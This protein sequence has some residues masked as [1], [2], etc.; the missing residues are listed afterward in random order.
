MGTIVSRK[1]ADGSKG[2][3]GPIVIKKLGQ[4]VHRE[5]QTIDSHARP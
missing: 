1:R 3:T 5:A 4:I 2:H